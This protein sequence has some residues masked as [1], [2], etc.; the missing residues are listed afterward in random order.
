VLHATA[1]DGDVVHLLDQLPFTQ[2]GKPPEIR[3]TTIFQFQ[4]QQAKIWVP[5]NEPA[6]PAG[7]PII[8]DP[9]DGVQ[10]TL[11]GGSYWNPGTYEDN[12]Q[13]ST[14]TTWELGTNGKF[15]QL[16]EVELAHESTFHLIGNL[17]IVYQRANQ[18]R[19]LDLSEPS[20]LRILGFLN[21][22]GAP[23]LNYEFADGAPDRG[24]WIPTGQ[25]GLEAVTFSP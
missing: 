10:L 20:A 23:S 18:P 9:I 14:L 11:I 21:F 12:P 3:G 13:K 5:S 15:V 4:P 8:G 1:L 19:L 7:D 25:Y 24:L 22:E 16:D 17:G 2:Y 6:P